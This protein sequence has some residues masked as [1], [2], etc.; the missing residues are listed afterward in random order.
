MLDYIAKDGTTIVSFSNDYAKA[1]KAKDGHSLNIPS[2]VLCNGASASAAELFTVGM[3]D[4]ASS[5]GFPIAIV[6]QTTY[7]KFIMQN[8]YQFS[9]GSAVT[10]TVA[11]YYSPAGDEYEGVGITPTVIV[12]GTAEQEEAAIYEAKK[13]ISK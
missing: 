1:E 6:G 5:N 4:I 11:Y 9:D 8:S 10:F 13:L 12:S 3:R 7:G 2:V